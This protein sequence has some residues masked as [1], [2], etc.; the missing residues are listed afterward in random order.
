VLGVWHPIAGCRGDREDPDGELLERDVV[1]CG[2]EQRATQLVILYTGSQRY[3]LLDMA[4]SAVAYGKILEAIHLGKPIPPDWAVDVDGLPTTDPHQAAALLPFGGPKG[5]GL[6]LA[7]DIFAG[8]LTGS[9]FGPYVGKMY[10][11]DPCER[12]RLGHFVCAI[13]VSR[14]TERDSFIRKIQRMIDDLHGMSPAP[15]FSGVMLPGELEALRERQRREQGIPLSEE[16]YAYL[17]EV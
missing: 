6:A 2:S 11:D 1:G 10:G 4:T 15:G 13:D 16:L 9:P 12:R 5:Y 7:V 17:R 8:I 14:F 3:G